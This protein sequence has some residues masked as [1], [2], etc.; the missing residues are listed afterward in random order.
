MSDDRDNGN[1]DTCKMFVLNEL[2]RMNDWLSKM[3]ADINNVAVQMTALKVKMGIIGAIAGLVV[4]AIFSLI[5]RVA[6]K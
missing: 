4:S 3:D 2:K 6:V 5:V 1:W